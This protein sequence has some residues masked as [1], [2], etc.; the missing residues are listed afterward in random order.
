M[1]SGSENKLNKDMAEFFI[2]RTQEYLKD[3]NNGIIAFVLTRAIFNGGQYDNL[4]RGKSNF[5]LYPEIIW[6]INENANPF[7]KPSCIIKFSKINNINKI[8]GYILKSITNIKNKFDVDNNQIIKEPTEFTLILTENYS[9]ITFRSNIQNN[10]LNKKERNTYDKSFRKGTDIFPRSYFF[11]EIIE[12]ADKGYKVNTR[13]TYLN[14]SNKRRKKGDYN[15]HFENNYVPRELVYD[16]ILGESINKFKLIDSQ[17]VVLPIV[18][19]DLIF[20]MQ[21]NKNNGYKFKLKVNYIYNQLFKKYEEYFNE[22]ENDWE[23]GRGEKFTTDKKAKTSS[24]MSVWDNLNH[25]NKLLKQFE[26]KNKEKDKKLVV[27]NASGKKIRSAVIDNLNYVIDYTS[28]YGLFND[29]EAFYLTGILNSNYLNKLLKETGILSERHI[30]KKP[31]DLPFPNFDPNNE[32]CAKISELSRKLHQI[33]QQ[34]IEIE[35]SKEF[36]EL[37]EA[38]K[39]LFE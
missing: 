5:H 9:S 31:F 30:S 16:A 25:N 13:R 24:R 19:S 6:D 17:K 38:V 27:Y 39:K 8:S 14:T 7:R 33:A 18:N 22:I 35:K 34:N 10:V 15:F 32:L 4:R 12:E 26:N 1:V 23:E 2:V 36:S 21:K 28:Y 20:T 29:N 3:K 11:I 37:D